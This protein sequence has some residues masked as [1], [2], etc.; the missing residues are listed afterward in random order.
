MESGKKD[1]T[2]LFTGNR[3]FYIPDYQRNYAWED[4]QLKDFFDDFKSNYNGVNKRYYYGTILLQSRDEGVREKYDIVDGQQRLTTLIIFIYCLLKRIKDIPNRGDDFDDDEIKKINDRF[5]ICKHNHILTLQA[6]DND[7]FRTYV[8]DDKVYS[9]DFRT[10][11][12][13]RLFHA[14]EKFTELLKETSDDVVL[15]FMNKIN[16]TNVLVYKVNSRSEASLIF[17]TTNDRGKQLT[18]IEKT[19]SYLM[20]KVSLLEDAEELLCAIQNR[21]NQIYQDYASFEEKQ[22]GEDSILQYTFI[23]HEEWTNKK[24]YQH[25]MSIMREK[26]ELLMEQ[27]K[28]SEFR[29][30]AEQYTTNLKESFSTMKKLLSLDYEE[31]KDLQVLG[32]MYNFY[33]LLIKTFK[34]DASSDKKSFRKICRLLEIFVFRVYLIRKK[35]THKFQTKWFNLAKQFNGNFDALENSII[36]LIKAVESGGDEKF[37]ADLERKDFFDE[38]SSATKNYFFWKYENYLRTSRQPIASVMPHEDLKKVKGNKAN[39][40]IEHIVAKKNTEEHS[41]VIADEGIIVVGHGAKFNE[42]YLNSIG[43]LTIDPQ[44]A[45][46]SKGKKDVDEKVS[47]YFNKAPYK[48]QNELEDFM[49]DGKW[50]IESHESRK[51]ALIQFAKATWCNYDEFYVSSA[52]AENITENIEEIEDEEDNFEEQ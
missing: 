20:Y 43:N 50:R 18:N 31:F 19:K 11:S 37:I 24:E 10:P 32:V 33:P 44:S 40:S 1:L 14:K 45:N 25:Y 30:Y 51:K 9:D 23:A 16:V 52:T 2:E 29:E 27:G 46:S 4:K 47:K 5:I 6:D 12:Q 22:I 34:L 36:G 39:L 3:Y 15:S 28:Y 17:E 38:Y 8:L 42:E 48:C 26:S 13:K 35:P 21:F 41:R 7:F 49:K